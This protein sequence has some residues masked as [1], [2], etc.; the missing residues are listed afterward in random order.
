MKFEAGIDDVKIDRNTLE[1]KTKRTIW[2]VSGNPVKYQDWILMY[3][4]VLDNGNIK[5]AISKPKGITEFATAKRVPL[6]LFC[7]LKLAPISWL[8]HL[9]KKRLHYLLVTFKKIIFHATIRCLLWM[10]WFL[11]LKQRI[12]CRSTDS[13]GGSDHCQFWFCRILRNI[14]D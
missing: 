10:P 4:G 3:S 11:P 8:K 9:R 6:W 13:A 12:C 1:F 14:S 2:A 7:P 5:F